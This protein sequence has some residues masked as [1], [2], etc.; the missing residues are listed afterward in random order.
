MCNKFDL[1]PWAFFLFIKHD[2]AGRK[3]ERGDI[4]QTTEAG[5]QYHDFREQ[6][7]RKIFI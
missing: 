4:Q 2:S 7:L 6:C 5:T 3:Q 1:I